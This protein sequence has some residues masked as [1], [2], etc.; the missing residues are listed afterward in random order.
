MINSEEIPQREANYLL[1][2]G[3]EKLQITDDLGNTNSQVND[4]F[5]LSIP[6]VSYTPSEYDGLFSHDLTMTT[7]REYTIKFRTGTDIVDIELVRGIGNETPN[8]A[9]RYI[10]LQ[11]PPNVDCLLTV[12]GQG[13]EDLR[14]DADGDGTFETVVPAH[15]RV[16]GAA[17]QDTTAP[18]V[19][20]DQVTVGNERRVTINAVDTESGVGTIYYRMVGDPVFQAYT[21]PFFI[22]SAQVNR[23]VE[24]FADDNVGNRSSP[25]KVTITP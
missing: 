15:V 9:V 14:Y 2:E 22:P 24:A 16:S 20:I 17:A 13:M 23:T 11:L 8:Y 3:V 10:D 12:T 25:V 1:I 6:N 18:T 5:E 4:Y 19:T 7:T 21:A